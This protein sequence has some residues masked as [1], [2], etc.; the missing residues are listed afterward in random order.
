M[1][2][3]SKF[4]FAYLYTFYKHCLHTSIQNGDEVSLS[5]SWADRGQLVKMR[6]T[7]ESHVISKFDQNVLT[8]TF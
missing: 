7:L 6:I 4:N 5:I 8:Y 3:F 2:F 1:V